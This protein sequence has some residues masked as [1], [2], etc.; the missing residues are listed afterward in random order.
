MSRPGYPRNKTKGDPEVPLK[1]NK[2]QM[3]HKGLD[4]SLYLCI[5]RAS[6]RG[7][8]IFWVLEEAIA[9]GVSIVQLREKTL[10]GRSLVKLAR[11][12]KDFLDQKGVP[13]IINDRVD[14]ALAVDA[15]GVHVGQEDIHPQDVRPLLGRD[16]IIGLSVNTPHQALEAELLPVD[17][18]GVGPI[19]PT[20]TKKDHKPV[21]YREG[22]ERILKVTTL[23]VVA[24]GGIKEENVHLISSLSSLGLSGIAVVSS[25]CGSSS[26]RH[27]A[28]ILKEALE[29]GQETF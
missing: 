18:I 8:D 9:G 29:S 14:V 2:G 13:L 28:K 21:L 5:D 23:P 12:V 19:F 15:T 3:P 4:L 20:S 26:P 11:E 17:Y 16:R 24:I 7:R 22:L 10:D 1:S 6:C 25:I 27:S